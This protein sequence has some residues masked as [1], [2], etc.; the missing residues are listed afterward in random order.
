VIDR[1]VTAAGGLADAADRAIRLVLRGP[2]YAT[3]RVS[4]VVAAGLL[5]VAGLAVVASFETPGPE[6]LSFEAGEVQ[7]MEERPGR[8]AASIQGGLAAQYAEYFQD[9]DL[10]GEWD[11]GEPTIEWDYFLVDPTTRQ[12]VTVRSERPADE[13]YRLAVAGRV[14]DADAAIAD[15]RGWFW[16]L[17]AQDLELE[18][19]AFID[20]RLPPGDPGVA[21]DLASDLP[22]VGT[23]VTI[24]AARGVSYVPRC[25]P[26][27]LTTICEDED[28]DAFDVLAYDPESRRAVVVRTPVSP[29]FAPTTIHGV[30]RHEAATVDSAI[31]STGW[32]PDELGFTVSPTLVL[33]DGATPPSGLPLLGLALA[34]V[35]LAGL[36]VVGG[37]AGY[38]RFRPAGAAAIADAVLSGA[39]DALLGPDDRIATRV[40]GT[41]HGRAGAVHVREAPADVLRYAT[42]LAPGA[43][44][45]VIVQRPD[46][47]QGV[48]VGGDEITTLEL[49]TVRSLRWERPAIRV[50]AGTGPL[51]LTFDD[52]AAQDRA[53][54]EIAAGD[55]AA[56]T[57]EASDSDGMPEPDPPAV[58]EE[59]RW[60]PGN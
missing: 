49:G 16:E 11:E 50:T 40:T 30:I 25:G 19:S 1:L 47:P 53:A 60:T 48:G 10:D 21:L 52:A 56:V 24:D 43:P 34:C 14:A 42:S 7:E 23:A 17:E 39:P 2:R 55:T 54:R 58:D 44:T 37:A 38:V 45:T 36:I 57:P 32:M 59:D 33:V 41:L 5:V 20:A 4:I 28:A 9:L 22:T 15:D 31:R 29:E 18:T 3:R 51:V 27:R 6:L 12:G 46:E 26:G 8:F 13:M 35:A